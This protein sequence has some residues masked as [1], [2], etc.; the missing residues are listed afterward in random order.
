MDINATANEE[1]N[2]DEQI[3]NA[4]VDTITASARISSMLP[5][6]TA[7]VAPRNRGH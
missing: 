4:L 5:E 2:F 7:A 3:L 1:A 6:A